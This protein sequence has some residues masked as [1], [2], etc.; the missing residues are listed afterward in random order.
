MLQPEKN[1][2]LAGSFQ[3]ALLLYFIGVPKKNELQ[4]GNVGYVKY[5]TESSTILCDKRDAI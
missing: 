1:K 4:D 3:K 2:K 5:Q